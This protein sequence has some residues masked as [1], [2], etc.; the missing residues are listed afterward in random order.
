M[1]QQGLAGVVEMAEA[2]SVHRTTIFRDIKRFEEAGAKGLVEKRRG[3][4]GPHVLTPGSA[5]S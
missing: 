2:F 3:P 5:S 1:I 4:K